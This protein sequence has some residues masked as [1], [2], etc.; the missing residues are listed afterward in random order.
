MNVMSIVGSPSGG[1]LAI[2]ALCGVAPHEASAQEPSSVQSSPV[3]EI[4]GPVQPITLT[5]GEGAL[6]QTPAPYT[7]ISVTDEKIVEV[8]PQSDRA[9]VFNP[10]EVGVTNVFILDNKNA[11]IATLDVRVEQNARGLGAAKETQTGFGMVRIYDR[12][13]NAQGALAKPA[14][15]QCD[16]ASCEDVGEAPAAG[17]GPTETR[18]ANS[19]GSGDTD[20]GAAP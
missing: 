5:L 19:K 4:N 16:H 17:P 15:Y 7:K 2:V 13:Y 3:R 9:F 6:F 18:P 1:V 20:A 14:L 8:T 12:I 10:R 11:L